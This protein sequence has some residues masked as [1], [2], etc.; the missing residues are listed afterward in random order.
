M[1]T[2]NLFQIDGQ[3]MPI[4]D[5][6]VQV[7]YEDIDA[8]Y[9]GRD[10]SGLM[11]RM[12]VRQNV[13]SWGFHYAVLTQEEKLYLDNLFAGKPT[14]TFT[15][16]GKNHTCYRSGVTVSWINARLGLWRGYGFTIIEC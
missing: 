4:P 8:A 13:G 10:E 6:E 14:F 3:A 12:P 9:A 5:E 7:R 1:E 16:N 11:H 2:T 15:C